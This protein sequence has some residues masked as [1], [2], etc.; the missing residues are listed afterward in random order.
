LLKAVAEHNGNQ[1][2]R[3]GAETVTQ[4]LQSAVDDVQRLRGEPCLAQ[5]VVAGTE[6]RGL[7]RN[8][9]GLDSGVPGRPPPAAH[10]G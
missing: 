2:C 1:I 5:A 7:P 6:T 8:Q 3:A 9:P 10:R 4:G